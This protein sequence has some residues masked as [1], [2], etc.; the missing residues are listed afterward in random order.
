MSLLKKKGVSGGKK[1]GLKIKKNPDLWIRFLEI[2]RKHNVSFFW[3]K[4]HNDH[5]INER[6]DKLAFNAC[7][8]DKLLIDKDYERQQ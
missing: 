4:G 3:I 2:Y 1:K 6:C 7:S 8:K 5:P